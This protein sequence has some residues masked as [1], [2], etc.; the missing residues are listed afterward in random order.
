LVQGELIG[1][2]RNRLGF[3]TPTITI[4]ELDV[5]GMIVLENDKKL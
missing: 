4:S 1:I 3:R 2:L 5:N